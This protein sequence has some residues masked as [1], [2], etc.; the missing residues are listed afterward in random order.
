MNKNEEYLRLLD[1]TILP[2]N[3]NP[4]ETARKFNKIIDFVKK[5][6]PGSVYRYRAY[7]LKNI[8]AFS[9]NLLF[10]SDNKYYT[11]LYD[12]SISINVESI[13]Q[14]LINECLK[15]DRID[16]IDKF[17]KIQHSSVENI[18]NN[19]QN[20]NNESLKEIVKSFIPY[21]KPILEYQLENCINMLRKTQYRSICFCET[22]LDNCMWDR[23]ADGHKGFCI[24]YNFMPGYIET[25]CTKC[26]H[27]CNQELMMCLLPVAYS[28]QKFDA[29]YQIKRLVISNLLLALLNFD[30]YNGV[31]DLLFPHKIQ[32][33]KEKTGYSN[34]K[35]WRLIINDSMC[36]AVHFP[37]KALYLGAGLLRHEKDKMAFIAYKKWIIVYDMKINHFSLSFDLEKSV[38]KLEA[39]M[40]Q[41]PLPL[42]QHTFT[43]IFRKTN[44]EIIEL[45]Y[46][47]I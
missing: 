37:P 19:L 25:I 32:L 38:Y 39:P 9:N 30:P 14:E 46:N 20:C 24:E 44:L 3:E 22:V 10:I 12:S 21:F 11:D 26:N 15:L 45:K 42:I 7:N 43:Y 8:S 28:K 23:Y 17:K 16:L 2:S 4:I 41:I 27:K 35:E 6:Y 29:T 40:N 47:I 13:N 34:E 31:V 5:D 36:K 33:H 18:I 1:S